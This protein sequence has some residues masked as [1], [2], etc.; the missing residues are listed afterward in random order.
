M[1]DAWSMTSLSSTEWARTCLCMW[2]RC[3][4]PALLDADLTAVPTR[5]SPIKSILLNNTLKRLWLTVALIDLRSN[6]QI[7]TVA[8]IYIRSNTI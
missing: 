3:F 4:G 5:R 2:P 1:R 7:Q 6:Y 8:L